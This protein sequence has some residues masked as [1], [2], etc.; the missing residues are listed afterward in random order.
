MLKILRRLA[1][2]AAAIAMAILPLFLGGNTALAADPGGAETLAAEPGIALDFVWVLMS[3]FLVFVMQGGFAMVEA[4]MCRAKN[5][6][7]LMMKNMKD[8][9]I[10]SL[11]FF[12]VGFAI[13]FGTD[14]A[15]LFGSSGWFLS[16]L[17]R[18]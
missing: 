7:N 11:A 13:M 5:A 3:A 12:T 14:N 10:G 1:V 6:I 9:C 8:F 18:M 16:G 2:G 4:G 15:G 17:L